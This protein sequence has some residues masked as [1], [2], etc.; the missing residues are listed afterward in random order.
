MQAVA[1]FVEQGL[2]FV[3]RQKCGLTRRRLGEVAG[4]DDERRDLAVEAFLVAERAHPGTAALGRACEIVAIKQRD[5][6]T[7]LEHFPDANVGMIERY[8]AAFPERDSE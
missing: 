1:E 8:V 4:V 7:V 5:M 3:E 2:G 6:A